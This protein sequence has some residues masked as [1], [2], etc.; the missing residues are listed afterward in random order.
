MSSPD[1]LFLATSRSVPVA[2]ADVFGIIED[3]S[4]DHGTR[5]MSTEREEKLLCTQPALSE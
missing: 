3:L 2:A 5:E 1:E 4:V